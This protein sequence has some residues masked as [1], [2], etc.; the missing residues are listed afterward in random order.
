MS[1]PRFS[2]SFEMY[3]PASCVDYPEGLS[4]AMA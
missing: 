1:S 2:E 4:V 3:V